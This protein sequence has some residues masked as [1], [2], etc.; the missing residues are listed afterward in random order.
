MQVRI[1]PPSHLKVVAPWTACVRSET[2]VDSRERPAFIKHSPMNI[3][4]SYKIVFF[5]GRVIKKQFIKEY[6]G[7]D[8]ANLSAF[9][10]VIH[11]QPFSTQLMKSIDINISEYPW[12]ILG[13]VDG[14]KFPM[15]SDK[16]TVIS[17]IYRQRLAELNEYPDPI[18]KQQMIEELDTARQEAL[19]IL[20]VKNKQWKKDF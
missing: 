19:I 14:R 2:K 11:A 7:I 10:D 5:D 8:Q 1:L 4:V 6:F 15:G 16:K 12:G 3:V 20:K 17:M 9:E 18:E 13:C